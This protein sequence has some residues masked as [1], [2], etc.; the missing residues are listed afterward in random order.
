[1]QRSKK[2]RIEVLSRTRLL[3]VYIS[4]L[5]AFFLFIIITAIAVPAKVVTEEAQLWQLPRP[6]LGDFLKGQAALN[7]YI[8][9]LESWHQDFFF[10]LTFFR[11]SDPASGSL[12]GF[13]LNSLQ[14]Q[15]AWESGEAVANDTEVDWQAAL[16]RVGRK[17]PIYK[18][19]L[20]CDWQYQ[21]PCTELKLPDCQRCTPLLLAH[22]SFITNSTYNIVFKIA[23]PQAASWH[24]F[25]DVLA[26][27]SKYIYS[28]KEFTFFEI[29]FRYFMVF[30]SVTVTIFYWS[31]V[32]MY[33][34]WNEWALEQKWTLILLV[35]LV[36]CNNPLFYLNFFFSTWIWPFL[37]VVFMCAYLLLYMLCILLF[38]D[39][40]YKRR[41]R[42]SNAAFYYP[43]L[44]LL[45]IMGLLALWSFI[46]TRLAQ[47]DDIAANDLKNVEVHGVEAFKIAVG[48]L[49]GIYFLWLFFL[50]G[51]V[52][53]Q[54]QQDSMSFTTR[55]VKFLWLWAVL[56]LAFVV[57]GLY[58]MVLQHN[59]NLNAME[60]VAFM[61][62][63]NLFPYLLAYF[64]FPVG[65]RISTTGGYK[66]A[67][68]PAA[69]PVTVDADVEN[70][71]FDE[72]EDI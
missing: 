48:V 63:F 54:W 56:I 27:Q 1:M 43:K 15:I 17:D 30:C 70:L 72:E 41:H 45:S 60:F 34:P 67:N 9:N 20:T 28:R 40:L 47:K 61:A 44:F 36:F 35:G 49:V 32:R 55:R 33:L 7:H 71:I 57:A 37:N 53:E 18:H 52:I 69:D 42:V 8:S 38:S 16:Q 59:E 23:N 50:I 39:N 3:A 46:T 24:L 58:E 6:I 21:Q 25:D 10:Y 2:F 4:A 65:G 14:L 13:T 26:V 62:V 68:V 29:G 11:K 22:E 66:S 19:V 64:Y 31:S 5:A 12:T 51:R